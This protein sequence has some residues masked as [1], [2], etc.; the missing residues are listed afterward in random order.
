MALNFN[1]GGFDKVAEPEVFL[2]IISNPIIS[3]LVP[4]A[5]IIQACNAPVEGASTPDPDAYTEKPF[6]A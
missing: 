5:V 4:I 3:E 1:A 2:A 6:L